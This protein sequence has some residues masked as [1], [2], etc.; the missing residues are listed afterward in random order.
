MARTNDVIIIGKECGNCR[1]CTEMEDEL[2]RAKIYCGKRD[3]TYW[4]G[5]CVP[6]EDKEV[7]HTQ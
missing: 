1:Y 3:K 4:Y 7:E 5:Q 6:C 2:G